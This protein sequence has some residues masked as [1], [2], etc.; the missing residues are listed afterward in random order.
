[1]LT[2]SATCTIDVDP[3]IRRIDFDIDIV[4]YF[5][6]YENAGERGVAAIA[7][8]ERR[9]SD[10]AVHAGFGSQPAVRI[11]A[12]DPYGR[13]FNAGDFAG[14]RFDDLRLITM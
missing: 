12:R 9:F 4:V 2:A 8:I 14:G 5:G 1:M 11:L 10:Q 7:G 6:R 13:A 3:Q